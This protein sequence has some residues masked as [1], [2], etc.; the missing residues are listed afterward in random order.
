MLLE[1]LDPAQ[2]VSS[3][4]LKVL[5]GSPDVQLVRQTL[6]CSPGIGRS[7]KLRTSLGRRGDQLLFWIAAI[8][9]CHARFQTPNVPRGVFGGLRRGIRFHAKFG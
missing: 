5:L 8:H 1:F 2:R 7:F 3:R 4:L 6:R 9:R